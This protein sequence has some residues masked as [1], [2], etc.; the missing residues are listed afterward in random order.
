MRKAAMAAVG[1]KSLIITAIL[2]GSRSFPMVPAGK[3]ALKA[4]RQKPAW[5]APWGSHPTP[6]VLSEVEGRCTMCLDSDGRT[7]FTPWA[8][9]GCVRY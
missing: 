4:R 3:Q 6:F 7:N 1:I 9:R 5:I 2:V 8:E